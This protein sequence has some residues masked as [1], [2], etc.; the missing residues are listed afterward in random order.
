M[1]NPL[2]SPLL[3]DLYQFTMLETYLQNGMDKTAVFEFY[4]RKLPEN[5]G[6]LIAAGLDSVLSFLENF[7]FSPGEIDY[8]AQTKRFS[9]KLLDYLSTCRFYGDVY[10]LPE[11]TV[12]F[13]NEPLIRIVAPL[14]VAQLVE[15]RVMNFLHFETTI[16]SK[17]ARCVLAAGGKGLVDFGLRRTHGAE[18]GILA[19]RAAYISGFAGTAT[20]IAE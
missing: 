20:V 19:A 7:E 9:P 15:T 16:A 8:L 11:G 3:T 13:A 4:V 18:A 5:R 1:I 14:P 12:C 17:A 6:F 10:A 2:T